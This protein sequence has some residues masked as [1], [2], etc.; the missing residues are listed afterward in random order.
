MLDVVFPR[1]CAGCGSGAWPFCADCR[2]RLLAIEP[3]W[4]RRCRAPSD[5]SLAYCMECPPHPIAVA[6]SPF[7]FAGP[8]RSAV[9]RLKFSGW[10]GIARAL[11]LAMISVNVF[12]PDAVCWVPLS[13]NRLAERGYDQARALAEVV[14][15]RLELPILPLL[16]RAVDASPQARRAGADR[17]LA[18]RGAFRSSGRAPPARV[19]I[20]DDVLTTG[21]TAA[22]CAGVLRAAGAG[23]IGLLTAARA[24]SGPVPGRRY[25]RSGSGL[26]L[27]L[28][29]DI[30][31]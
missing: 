22:E 17:R 12:E 4:C 31:R 28:P 8:A 13:R 30:P 23:E 16:E 18:L 21:A 2:R 7:V 11:G 15:H 29:E 26:G 10:R 20:V 24:V 5:V 27:W 9:H 6:R 14:G 1:R 19:L 3:P 25:T